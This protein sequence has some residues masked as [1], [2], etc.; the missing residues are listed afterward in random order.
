M[1][2]TPLDPPALE[3]GRCRLLAQRLGLPQAL[4][5]V[6][7]RRGVQDEAGISAFLYPNL[8]EL[9]DPDLMRGMREASTIMATAVEEG[10]PIVIYADYDADGVTAGALLYLFLRRLGHRNLHYLLPHRITDGYG[11]HAHLLGAMTQKLAIASCNPLLIT[12][13]CGISDHRAVTAAKELG[14]TVI[15]TDHHR[16]P[17]ILPPAAAILNPHQEGCPFPHKELAG[18]GVAFYLLMGLRRRLVQ[19]GRPAEKLPNLKGYLDLV[20]LGTV[21]DMVSVRGINRILVKAGLAVLG[22]GARPGLAALSAVAGIGGQPLSTAD[23]SFQLAPRIN[24]AGR[25]ATPETA[26]RL[27]ISESPAEAADLAAELEEMNR[28]RRE[29][30]ERI[31]AEVKEKITLKQSDNKNILIHS[32]PEWHPGVLGIAA[33]RLSREF[34]RPTILFNLGEGVARGSGRSVAGLDLLAAVTTCQEWLTGYGGHAAALGLSLDQGHLAA[35]SRQLDQEVG[36]LMAEIPQPPPAEPDWFFP[37][38]RLDP[39]LLEVYPLLEPFGPGNPEPLFGVQGKLERPGIVGGNHLRFRWRQPGL[40]CSG[41]AFDH[42]ADLLPLSHQTMN[43]TFAFQRNNYQ[44]RSN[45]QMRVFG[46]TPTGN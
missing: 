6:L 29:L 44:G 27:L 28:Q 32:S 12:V 14:Y 4:V 24:A 46:I 39:R 38:G 41:I 8:Q 16:P 20:A 3:P 23:I 19:A 10:R 5:A 9:P 18:V 34:Q 33:T 35:F 25:I 31:S 43:L 21:A 1:F 36:R 2:D 45:W 15:I 40:S 11:V 37:D 7:W 22:S 26:F 13:D 42:G 17:A 30:S